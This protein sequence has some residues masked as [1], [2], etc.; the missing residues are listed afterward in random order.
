MFTRTIVLSRRFSKCS[1]TVEKN[2]LQLF[3]YVFMMVS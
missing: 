1:A 3:V 2:C